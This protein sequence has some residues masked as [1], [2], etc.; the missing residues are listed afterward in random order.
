MTQFTPKD[1]WNNHIRPHYKAPIPYGYK[2][3]EE[4]DLVAVPD[5][6]LVELIEKALDSMDDGL[7][8]RAISAWL[9]NE[10]G[11]D[12]SYQTLYN[13][14]KR[15]R[16]GNRNYP[17]AKAMMDRAKKN[18]PK[19]NKDKAERELKLKAAGARRSLTVANKKLAEF[20]PP[21]PEVE[22]VQSWMGQNGIE[23]ANDD[24]LANKTVIFRPNPGPQ[25]Q[26]LAAVEQEVLYGGSAGGG[27]SYALLADP[28]RYFGH[29]DFRG[30]ILR[31]TND[32]MR[33]LKWKSKEL[34]TRAYPGAKW[35]ENDSEWVFPSGARLWMTYLERDEDVLRYQGQSFTYIAIDELTQYPTPHAWDYMRSRLRT[36]DSEE[37]L[38][39]DLPVFMRATTNPGGPGHGW[40]KKMFID[41]APYN[42]PFD[43]TDLETDKPL[44]WPDDP[45]TPEGLAG[46][47]LFQ[48]RFIPAKLSDNPYLNRGGQYRANLL[49]LSEMKRRQLLEGDWTI[50]EGAAFPEFR[51]KDHVVAPFH[52]PS[53]WRKFR[54]C[55]YGY[56][57]WSAVH[58]YAIDPEYG[59]IVVYRELYVSK[60]TG[61]DLA[62]RILELERGETVQYGMLDSSCWHQRG[63]TGPSIAE[64]MIAGGTRWR[65]A[66]R[67]S[68]SR[69]NGKN[70]LHELLKVTS[71][72]YDHEGKEIMLPGIVFFDNCRQIIADLPVIPSDPHG[73][74]DIDDRYANDHAYDSIRYGIMSRPRATSPFDFGSSGTSR[75]IY[76]PA[77]KK[78]GY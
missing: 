58:W 24:P 31:R 2:V 23:A 1:E 25:S 21:E 28:L 42:T 3:N 17:Y 7:S 30:L 19:T 57:T 43:A 69:A 70:R 14:Y 5:W 4:T 32:E 54:S 49:S 71:Y 40:V 34:Y 56:S 6:P 53:S 11:V 65:P 36:A 59:T 51:M 48:R 37:G 26:F 68:G 33:E 50:A 47:P 73:E 63:Q 62:Q 77:D 52:I 78:F 76:R 10:S 27:K 20:A 18:R 16:G 72:G 12:L 35:R 64:E 41:P 39:G 15:K 55:D 66:D 44:L 67:S 60:H 45:D 9:N 22:Q 74:D 29:K 8:V 13:I 38:P 75:G 46:K 61:R